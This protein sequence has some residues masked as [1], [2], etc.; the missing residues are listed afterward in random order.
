MIQKV[1]NATFLTNL[2]TASGFGTFIF[3]QSKLLKEFGVVAFI[4]ILLIFFIS[5]ITLPI[6]FS[7]FAPPK[8]RHIKHLDKRWLEKF[9]NVLVFLVSKMRPVVY[10]FSLL[11]LVVA[12]FGLKRIKVTGNY[13]DDIPKHDQVYLDLKFFESHFNGIMPFEIV[14]DTKKQK[15]VSSLS[16]LKRIEKLQEF[17]KTFPQFSRSLSIVDGIKFIRQAYYNGNPQKYSLITPQERNFIYP[18]I[19]SLEKNKKNSII[20]SFIDSTGR[21][22]RISLNVKDIGVNELNQL[23]DSIKP[24]SKKIFPDQK[25]SLSF[26]GAILVFIKGTTYLTKNLFISLG[27]AVL[28]ISFIMSFLFGSFRMVIISLIP[29]IIPLIITASL[30]GYFNIPIKPSTILVFSIAFG[31]SVDDTIHFL[32]KFRQELKRYQK[33]IGKSVIASLKETGISM[34]YTSVVLF[35]GFGIFSISSFGGTQAL[36]ILV[37]VTLLVAMF[38]NLV[39]LPSLLLSLE[40]RILTKSFEESEIDLDFSDEEIENHIKGKQK[41]FKRK[42]K[43]EKIKN[44]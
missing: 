4:D 43:K 24:Y 8:E 17:L 20:S 41:A 16:T 5:I 34:M 37:S 23:L 44:T 38:S 21:Y 15:G 18:Y 27:I 31:I 14:V 30:M 29:N 7:F 39:L 32:A 28:I 26:T 9:V 1:G 25:Y 33:N 40:K 42:N 11:I 10:V 3:T 2:T 36:G 13:T 12:F 6:I 19:K 22:A 35:F